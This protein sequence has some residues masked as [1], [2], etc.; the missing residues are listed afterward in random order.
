[1]AY[2]VFFGGQTEVAHAITSWHGDALSIAFAMHQAG[3]AVSVQ[4]LDTYEI[5]YQHPTLTR[6][7]LPQDYDAGL[8]PVDSYPRAMHQRP[9]YPTGSRINIGR[10]TLRPGFER[11]GAI[12]RPSCMA[13]GSHGPNGYTEVRIG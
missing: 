5:T 13:A 4:N 12:D 8:L 9:G 10:G 7:L 11:D 6:K 2:K 1:M 3:Y